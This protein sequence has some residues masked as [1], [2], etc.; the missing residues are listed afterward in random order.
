M[1]TNPRRPA[2]LPS[3]AR[4]ALVALEH[5]YSHGTDAEYSQALAHLTTLAT[6]LTPAQ[7]TTLDERLRARAHTVQTLA[8]TQRVHAALAAGHTRTV[9]VLPGDVEVVEVMGTGMDQLLVTMPAVRAGEDPRVADL[10]TSARQAV[11]TGQCPRCAARLV[12][13]AGDQLVLEHARRCPVRE[14][15]LARARAG[16]PRTGERGNSAWPRTPN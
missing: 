2:R 8:F 10:V 6:T 3:P 5:A 1:Q 12:A 13:G 7:R 4:R 11:L 16:A 14:D 9:Q 15:A